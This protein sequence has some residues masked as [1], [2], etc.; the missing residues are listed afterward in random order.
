MK[1]SRTAHPRTR[2]V[3]LRAN[4]ACSSWAPRRPAA[5]ALSITSPP[6]PLVRTKRL[7]FLP[8]STSTTAPSSSPCSY[9][10]PG[11]MQRVR[12]IRVFPRPGHLRDDLH[13]PGREARLVLLAVGFPGRAVGPAGRRHLEAAHVHHPPLAGLD[14]PGSRDDLV[15]LELV[16]VA[17]TD[18]AAQVRAG[19]PLV[20]QRDPLLD[21]AEHQ[22]VEEL[23]RAPLVPRELVHLLRCGA[24]RVVAAPRDRLLEARHLLL[25]LQLVTLLEERRVPALVAV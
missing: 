22:L 1:A 8:P 20:G 18:E 21:P 19:D 5:L 24:K 17:G 10:L 14:V 16:V 4:S 25:A 6:Y 7:T 2:P 12:P 23:V 3:A 15:D 9:E 11:L 13:D